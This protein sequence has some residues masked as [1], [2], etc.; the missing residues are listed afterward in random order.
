MEPVRGTKQALDILVSQGDSQ[1]A[2][3]L[4]RMGR[5][6]RRLVPSCIGLSLTFVAEDLTFTLVAT[7]D[8]LAALHA[9]APD[10]A[11]TAQLDGAP[12]AEDLLDERLWQQYAR[13][14]AAAGVASSLSLPIVREGR[15]IGSVSLYAAAPDA[16]DA[17]R[18]ALAAAL[19]V[20]PQ[21]AVAN[22]DL[23]FRSRRA[24]ANA[25]HQ[26]TDAEDVDIAV[27]LVAT[28]LHVDVSDAE[29]RLADA[30]RRVGI[31]LGQAARL[32]RFLTASS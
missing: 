17:G 21:G 12:A 9:P 15:T 5:E 7:G 19:G 10:P 28:L 13:A 24:A 32:L 18:D 23:E 4:M 20:S 26:L 3:A 22:A 25:P 6:A 31:S 16:F 11:R 30:A 2:V 14:S 8:E 29:E 27:G 1:V